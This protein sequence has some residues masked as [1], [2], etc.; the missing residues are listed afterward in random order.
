MY[1]KLFVFREFY[2][3]IL[4]S[5]VG[6]HRKFPSKSLELMNINFFLKKI[7]YLHFLPNNILTRLFKEL[8][9]IYE[10]DYQ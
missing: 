3:L 7:D 5:N 10:N 6:P 1:H 9:N 8:K 2:F 4:E